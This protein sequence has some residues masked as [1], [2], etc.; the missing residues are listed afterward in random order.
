VQ[1]DHYLSVT[2]SKLDGDYS[3]EGRS[4]IISTVKLL[5]R[6]RNDEGVRIEQVLA[7]L[8]EHAATVLESWIGR[9]EKLA[10]HANHG[11]WQEDIWQ[12]PG[13]P[14]FTLL[15]DSTE[16]GDGGMDDYAEAAQITE[17]LD[18]IGLDHQ[19]PWDME[20]WVLMT[21][22]LHGHITRHCH[23]FA[24]GWQRE[25]Q[26]KWLPEASLEEPMVSS[27]AHPINWDT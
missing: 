27:I 23:L 13:T 19:G 4:D 24:D 9:A 1:G 20:S 18:A 26:E 21:K 6:V 12:V 22:M 11:H 25:R 16:M 8:E 14:R 2:G 10:N 7:A 15:L 3:F 5:S 17:Y